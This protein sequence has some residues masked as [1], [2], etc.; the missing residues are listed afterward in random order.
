MMLKKMAIMAG[1]CSVL[2]A[3]ASVPQPEAVHLV[4]ANHIVKKVVVVQPPSLKANYKFMYGNSP[5]LEKAY[6][7]YLKTG[8]APN[9]VTSGFVQ[10]AYGTGSQPVIAAGPFELTV[11]SLEPGELVTNVSSGD[12]TRWSYSMAYSGTGNMRQA[13]IMVKPAYPDISTNLVITT[14]KRMYTLKIVS[15]KLGGNYVKNVSFWYPDEAQTFWDR[16]NAAQ[17]QKIARSS[18]VSKTANFNIRHLNFDYSVSCGGGIFSHC[19]AWRP[20]RVFDNGTHTYIQFPRSIS[21][22]TMPALFVV[23]GNKKELVNYRVKAPYF[24]VDKIF[25]RAVLIVG[26]GSGQSSVT[27]TNNR[28]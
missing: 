6:A 27:I 21:N 18:T 9:I 3:C 13:H 1:L 14:N 17:S 26:V 10:F 28:Y 4:Q 16:Y 7:A 12:P 15:G 2:T 24:V 8:R 25:Q 20:M 5:A 19:P 23:S 22:K 11:I